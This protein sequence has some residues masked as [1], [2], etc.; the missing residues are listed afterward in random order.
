MSAGLRVVTVVFV[1]GTL[2]GCCWFSHCLKADEARRARFG[3]LEEQLVEFSKKVNAYYAEHGGMPADFSETKFFE[4]LAAVYPAAGPDRAAATKIKDTYIV[5]ARP[6]PGGSYSV[7]LCDRTSGQ[8][9]LEDLSCRT[10]RVE[11]RSWNEGGV[12]ACEFERDVA[13][14][15]Q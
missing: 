11:I 8:K 14:Y 7:M 6:I 4:T 12:S 1:L 3:R 2:P 10:T 13:S 5:R 9:L 15:C